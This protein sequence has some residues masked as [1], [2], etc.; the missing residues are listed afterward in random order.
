[1]INSKQVIIIYQERAKK[2]NSGCFIKMIYKNVRRT[3][4]KRMEL[5]LMT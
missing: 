1:M 5:F 3:L 2:A 4:A